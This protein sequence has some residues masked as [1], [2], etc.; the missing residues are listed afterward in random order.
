MSF[1][2]SDTSSTLDV[3][4]VASSDSVDSLSLVPPSPRSTTCIWGLLGRSDVAL[5]DGIGLLRGEREPP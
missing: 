3:F 1:G 4:F 5:I 2:A